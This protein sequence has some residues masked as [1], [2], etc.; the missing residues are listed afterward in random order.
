MPK[1]THQIEVGMEV[2]WSLELGPRLFP[3]L[4]THPQGHLP[5]PPPN[6]SHFVSPP[7]VSTFQA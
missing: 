2:G 3:G 5:S 6:S 1:V 7:L 4:C